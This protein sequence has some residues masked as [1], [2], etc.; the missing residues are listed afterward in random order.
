MDRFIKRIPRDCVAEELVEKKR[1][2]IDASGI[3]GK[4]DPKSICIWNCNGLPVRLG[5]KRDRDELVSFI[6]YIDL[7]VICFSEVRCSA[8]CANKSAKRNDGTAR[9]RQ[10]FSTSTP[11]G[12]KDRELFDK[13][14]N[15]PELASYKAYIS[16]ADWK[17]R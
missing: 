6:K 9:D 13:F 8:F 17:V 7:D 5:Q 3:Y 1:R 10:R 11:T 16:L 15:E 12:L 14:M 2:R 4:S